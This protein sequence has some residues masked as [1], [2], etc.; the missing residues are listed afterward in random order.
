MTAAQPYEGPPA[1]EQPTA[2]V[3]P[4]TLAVAQRTLDQVS[5]LSARIS[6]PLLRVA[7]GLVY[8]WF[9]GLKV[10]GRSEV[11]N[12]V[13]V[14]LPFVNPHVF[15]P[16]LGVI[17]VLLGIGLCSGKVPRLVLI[18]VLAH[19]AGTFLTF[20]TAPSWMW[21]GGDPLLLT[22]DGEFVLKNVVLISAVLV[23]LGITSKIRI[24][25][26]EGPLARRT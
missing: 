20:I 6:L 25:S 16:I 2:T 21:R 15:V 11:F 18:G 24:G 4:G 3:P 1:T 8:V 9:G 17:E 26:A 12:L 13:G 19:L 10:V 5:A 7:L 14:T 23:L 22:T